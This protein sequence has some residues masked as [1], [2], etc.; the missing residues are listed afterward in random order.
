MARY[1]ELRRHTDSDG[2]VLTEDGV[3]AALE[4]G[5][6]LAG[7][8]ALLVS[9]GAQRATQTLACFA[10]VLARPVSGGVIVEPRLRS[11]VEDRWRAAYQTAGSGELSA[12]REA[13]PELAREDS[14]RL[15]DGLR[16]II[17]RLSDG[18]RDLAVG[19]SPAN[20][21]AVFGLSGQ[22]VAPISKGAGVLVVAD[23]D[24]ARVEPL[25]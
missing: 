1:V 14:E 13:D 10:C 9:S 12:L 15:A 7:P 17:E 21:A 25:P 20:E 8:Y 2:D 11:D 23:G 6:R 16:R 19:H 22:L 5:R 3:R 18:G 4:I 24:R